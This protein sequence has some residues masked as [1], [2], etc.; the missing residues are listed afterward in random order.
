MARMFFLNQTGNCPKLFPENIFD[1]IP[2]NYPV[3]LVDA[4]V[5]SL[6]I[7]DVLKKYKGGGTSAYHPRMKIIPSKILCMPY[8]A[9][10]GVYRTWK[11]N[12]KKR[13]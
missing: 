4:V 12:F 6:D 11:A 3:C 10:N 1:K 8:D 2:Q 9:T 13:R 7:S 5:D